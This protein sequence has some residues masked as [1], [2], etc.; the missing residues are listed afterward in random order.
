MPLEQHLVLVTQFYAL[1]VDGIPTDRDAVPP[2]AHGAV[3]R[4]PSLLEPH[5]LYLYGRGGDGG[6]LEDGADALAGLDGVL[7]DLVVRV[8][9][10]LARQVV[11]LPHGG[12]EVGFDPLLQ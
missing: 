8:V 2:L 1:D 6:L 11:G 9:S 3:G 4:S 12:V 10:R 5:L 7:Q